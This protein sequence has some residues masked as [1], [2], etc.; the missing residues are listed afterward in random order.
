MH[1]EGDRAQTGLRSLNYLSALQRMSHK[2]N[3]LRSGLYPT[4]VGKDEKKKCSYIQKV[5]NGR[6]L[7]QQEGKE[8]QDM[9]STRAR[10]C[11]WQR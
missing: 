9:W 3:R 1:Q 5:I 10:R 2:Y 6:P 8:A 7:G 4:G 11:P